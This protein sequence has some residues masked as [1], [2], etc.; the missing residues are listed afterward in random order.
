[1]CVCVCVCVCVCDVCVTCVCVRLCS[2]VRRLSTFFFYQLKKN[3]YACN[4]ITEALQVIHC[5]YSLYVFGFLK[6]QNSNKNSN[7]ANN[8]PY[9]SARCVYKLP[10]TIG[11][12]T[13]SK[14]HLYDV[15]TIV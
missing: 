2:C 7:T 12:N 3:S 9:T 1:M 13:Q 4:V 6:T 15:M 5:A 8:V 11:Q 10:R 14:L